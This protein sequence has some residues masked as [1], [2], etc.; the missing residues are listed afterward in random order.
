MKKA[1]FW[2]RRDLRW[3]DNRALSMACKEADEVYPVFIFDKNILS[4]LPKDDH[5]VSF[6]FER[7]EELTKK[8]YIHIYFGDPVEMIPKIMKDFEADAVFTNEDYESYAIK[9]DK[10]V[11]KEIDLRKFLD[12]IIFAGDEI[13]T[14]QGTPYKVYTPYKNSWLKKLEENPERIFEFKYK[15]SKLVQ[16][17]KTKYDQVKSL[18][19]IDFKK[20]ENIELIETNGEKVFKNYLDKVHEYKETRDYPAMDNTSHLATHF[21]FGTISTRAVC[22]TLKNLDKLPE[23][24]LSQIIWRDFFYSILQNFSYVEDK[25]F[26][27]QYQDMSW[28]ED[29][30][31]LKAWKEGQTGFPIIDAGMRELNSTGYM[32]NRVRMIVASFLTKNLL[33]DWRLGESYFAEK[34]YD[35]DLAVNNGSWQWASSTGCD[36]QPYFRVF[37]PE[38]QV[39]KFDPDGEY[40]YKWV[41]ELKDV[42][43]K[44]FHQMEKF[45]EKK[46]KE[47]GVIIG[48]DYP[49]PLV[50][51]KQTRVR[52][53]AHFKKYSS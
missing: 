12:H 36:A 53:I 17:Y 52:A 23:T 22:R 2:M 24:W 18:E 39:K 46:Q 16:K 35:Y 31:A 9:R 33:M 10:E 7:L 11:E 51:L 3:S 43:A 50:D 42:P 14:G 28:R 5:R 37:N 49:E 8:H 27:E 26:N 25:E 29:K 47:V 41:P 32:H 45:D 48:K 30:D 20:T 21:R 6:I 4:K 34:L 38:S 1:I 19:D 44:Y 15:P 13:K 40:I